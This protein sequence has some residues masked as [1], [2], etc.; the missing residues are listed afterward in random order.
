M[1]KK[2]K[3]QETV[4]SLFDQYKDKVDYDVIIEG[5]IKYKIQ[6][7][8]DE[9]T[10][11]EDQLIEGEEQI[12]KQIDLL[13]TNED[14][15]YE[16]FKDTGIARGR[17][18][19]EFSDKDINEDKLYFKFGI[20]KQDAEKELDIKDIQYYFEYFL[21]E[22]GSD[23]ESEAVTGLETYDNDSYEPTWVELKIIGNPEV[24]ILKNTLKEKKTEEL[25]LDMVDK[26]LVQLGNLVFKEPTT[27][28]IIEYKLNDDGIV[29]IYVDSKLTNTLPFSKLA[30]Q[31]ECKVLEQKGCILVESQKEDNLTEAEI[32][33][34][35]E[36][37]I[38]TEQTEQ[39]LQTAIQDVDKLQNLKDELMDKVDTLVNES[40]ENLDEADKQI[41]TFN[42]KIG[43]H[44]VEI[45]V[46]V[47]NNKPH[48]R[49]IWWNYDNNTTSTDFL[50]NEEEDKFYA[51]SYQNFLTN[52]QEQE[53]KDKIHNILNNEIKTENLATEDFPTT[54][55][56]Q[57]V[58]TCKDIQN[59]DLTDLLSVEQIGWLTTHFGSIEDF[60][61]SLK[62]LCSFVNI[63]EDVPFISID[64]YVHQ[65]KQEGGIK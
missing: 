5:T 55:D 29:E 1:N 6:G 49:K 38:D 59:I 40:K 65:L 10:P 45:E 50:Y 30:V 36:G 13:L 63:D 20:S 3:I 23:I 43:T 27:G 32:V 18:Y 33:T 64:E 46:D 24:T 28:S 61:E 37:N 14:Y 31:R 2:N 48:I 57:K 41:K 22:L 42:T 44:D 17:I 35:N 54:K 34:D 52:K 11:N 47:S 51:F 60:E 16:C 39:K 8:E 9:P 25:N 62:E 56:S 58:L 53:L 15:L 7:E 21:K 12:F 19:G 4:E 26:L